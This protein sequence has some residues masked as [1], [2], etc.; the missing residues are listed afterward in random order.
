MNYESRDVWI[1]ALVAAAAAVCLLAAVS[2]NKERL[3]AETYPLEIRLPN[4]AG[5][6]KGVEVICQG[7]KAGQVEQVRIAYQPE[8]QFVVRLAI[9][10]EMRLKRGTV[11][12]VRN[13]GF[14]GAKY[15]ELSAPVKGAPEGLVPEGAVM[16]VRQEGDLMAKADQ[17]MGD[18]GRVVRDFERS[19]TSANIGRTVEKANAALASLGALLEENRA[20][21][22][23]TL[24]H[25]RGAAARTDELMSKEDAV[26]RQT[27]ENLNQS[28]A[29][30][31]ESLSHLPTIMVNLEALSADLRRRPWRL[32]RKGD[33]ED[34]PVDLQHSHAPAV[35]T[36]TAAP[37]GKQ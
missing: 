23:S 24:E 34:S 15:L 13:K 4:I 29:R 8:L 22:R 18:L 26:L 10:R 25:A 5:I 21:L 35:R 28:M 20:A 17:V 6:D 37:A 36:S 27:L 3:T 30:L 14:G 12:I 11:V 9:K 33:P 31:N 2:I 32:I 16:P 19:G 7:Y 1:G